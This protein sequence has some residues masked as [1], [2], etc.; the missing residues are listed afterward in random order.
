MLKKF[1]TL[2]E[3]LVVIRKSFYTGVAKEMA[4]LKKFFTLVELLVVI[5]IISI[6][7]ALLLPALQQARRAAQAANCLSNLKQFGLAFT[8]YLNDNDDNPMYDTASSAADTSDPM[9]LNRV[10]YWANHD[11]YDYFGGRYLGMGSTQDI[12][13]P[14]NIIDCPVNRYGFNYNT[15]AGYHID[16][17]LYG[18]KATQIKRPSKVF[19][20]TDS[21][22]LTLST[23]AATISNGGWVVIGVNMNAWI[24]DAPDGVQYIHA[25]AANTVFLGGHAAPVRKEDVV[26]ESFVPL[27]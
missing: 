5:A 8:M 4:M 6:L 27:M 26:Y 10:W 23:N 16:K 9:Y 25:R 13:R 12:Y 17:H 3:L 18:R 7:A 2:V 20:F 22:N 14:G 21:G 19:V 15:G 1:F 11:K 24:Y